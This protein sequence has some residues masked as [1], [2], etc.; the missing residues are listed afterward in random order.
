MAQPISALEVLFQ[1]VPSTPTNAHDELVEDVLAARGFP[2]EAEPAQFVRAPARL[3][4]QLFDF[5]R[6]RA[7]RPRPA[8]EVRQLY[9]QDRGLQRVEA[10]IPAHEPVVVTRG[11]AVHAHRAK[12][13]RPRVE[14]RRHHAAIAE[15]AEVLR[16]E[17]RERR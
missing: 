11:L 8:V 12:L 6:V 9:M 2:G 15:P 7:P 4:I 3:E 13:R 16:W 14:L 5:G 17:E 10:E 1:G